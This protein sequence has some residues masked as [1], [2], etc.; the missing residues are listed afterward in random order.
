MSLSAEDRI[1]VWLRRKLLADG[2]DRLG[3]D[4]AILPS[5][6]QLAVSQDHQIEG[7]HFP[8][9]MAPSLVAYRLL[10]VNLSDLAAMGAEP[11]YAF[12]ALA[13]PAD[14]DAKALLSGFLT[15]S[16]AYGVELAGGD[17]ARSEQLTT[18]LTLLG[19]RPRGGSWVR[20]SNALPGDRLWVT[21][22]LG[23]SALGCRVL[24]L[25]A[26]VSGR[27][28]R[29]P[30]LPAMTRAEERL[31]RR[32]VWRHLRP[33]PQ[34]QVGRWLARRRRAAAI[35]I[36]DGLSL[37]LHR[38][39]RESGC[40]ARIE[41]RLLAPDRVFESVCRLLDLRPSSLVLA[42]GEDYALLFAL[43]PRVVPPPELHC[44]CI[45]V[46]LKEK[47]ILLAENGTDHD[48]PAAG[49]DHFDHRF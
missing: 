24:E 34:I 40:G 1:H 28:V 25:G 38:L 48:L 29:L 46:L 2:H 33:E 23:M 32:C 15:A 5:G 4:G 26:I 13:C 8:V 17:L 16:Q 14:Y 44:Q 36:S 47:A 21:G 27:R 7:V 6:R 37:D 10:A 20:R 45:G 39:C 35:D 41:W 19:R 42:G 22:P 31:V 11:A 30:D 9:G 49:W 43:P 18:S 3:D 12:L